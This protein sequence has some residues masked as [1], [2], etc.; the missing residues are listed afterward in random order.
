MVEKIWYQRFSHKFKK[1]AD[2]LA[3]EWPWQNAV[4]LVAEIWE[5]YFLTLDA[6]KSKIKILQQ[7]VVPSEG[8]LTGLQMTTLLFTLLLLSCC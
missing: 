1:W 2:V 4:D 6:G 8:S 3:V 5:T 7:D